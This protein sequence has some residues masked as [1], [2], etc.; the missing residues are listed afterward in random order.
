MNKP[1]MS[2]APERI[3]AITEPDDISADILGD[4]YAQQ[5]PDGMNGTPVEYVRADRIEE[6]E[7]ENAD[8][9]ARVEKLEAEDADRKS[10]YVDKLILE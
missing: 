10:Y 2:D 6:L 8:L 7:A 5:V 9:R 1:K 4:V 3:W